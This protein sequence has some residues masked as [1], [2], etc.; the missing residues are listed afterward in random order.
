MVESQLERKSRQRDKV[1]GESVALIFKG[2]QELIKNAT[3]ST[4]NT[5]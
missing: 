3:V 1:N 4:W 2:L 5:P